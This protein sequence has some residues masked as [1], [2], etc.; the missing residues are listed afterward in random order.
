MINAILDLRRRSPIGHLKRVGAWFVGMVFIVFC[1]GL[2]KLNPLALPTLAVPLTELDR[3]IPF[4][5]WTVWPYGTV[6]VTA[7]IAWLLVPDRRA[8]ARFAV[9]IAACSVVCCLFFIAVPTAYPRHLYPTPIGVSATLTE[10][11]EL[12][13]ADSPTNCFPSLHVALAW[14][15]APTLM[16]RLGRFGPLIAWAWASVVAACTLTTKQHFVVD[17]PTGMAI[18]SGARWLAVRWLP[19]H[20]AVA[21]RRA[22]PTVQP[23]RIA[24][25]APATPDA[26]VNTGPALAAV[27]PLV[28]AALHELA[29]AQVTIAGLF[30]RL[31]TI[32]GAGADVRRLGAAMVQQRLDLADALIEVG[33]A[34]GRAQR[35][36]GVI[37]TR[38]LSELDTIDPRTRGD[39]AYAAAMGL[40]LRAVC[41]DVALPWLATHPAL[42]ATTLPA[43]SAQ[44]QVQ[45]ATVER[46]EEGIFRACATGGLSL[47][48]G[49][50]NP[51][52]VRLFWQLPTIA[53]SVFA[54]ATAR[55][56]EHG[57]LALTLRTL[58]TRLRQAAHAGSAQTGVV[59]WPRLYLSAARLSVRLAA[60]PLAFRAGF[61]A[62][63]RIF[64]AITDGTAGWLHGDQLPARRRA[65][66]DVAA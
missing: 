36:P 62:P 7:F 3:A 46:A 42:D 10:I 17:L 57:R 60:I 25:A 31:A 49:I 24:V 38:L 35:R 28:V 30:G 32:D 12:R 18:G 56:G 63:M 29:W 51:S 13:D 9:A 14:A 40:T 41:D 53:L 20:A 54:L 59:T 11:A 22:A 6:T 52:V 15:I 64:V 4:I 21:L 27:D 45:R 1:Y 47:F 2:G 39:V 23:T 55:R 66:L 26:D 44:V 33:T 48:A 5:P 37:T 58:Q 34:A 8:A 65:E 16:L 43:L 50:T 61:A 19:D